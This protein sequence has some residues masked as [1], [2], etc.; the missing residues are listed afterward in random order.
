[1]LS[2][3]MPKRDNDCR[4][5]GSTGEFLISWLLKH[6]YNIPSQRFDIEAFDVIAFDFNREVFKLGN[7]PFFIQV[8]CM[9]K[10]LE[11]KESSHNPTIS[12]INKLKNYADK[13][14]LNK[15]SIYYAMGLF[16]DDI[17]N[18]NFWIIPLTEMDILL[19]PKRTHYTLSRQNLEDKRKSYPNIITKI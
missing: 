5:T 8:K 11:G 17:R 2:D 12:E 1:M 13:L 14:H 9:N 6:N 3:R 10:E 18:V 16:K 4:L 19:N 7:A 15:D